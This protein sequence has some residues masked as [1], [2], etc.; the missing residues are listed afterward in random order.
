MHRLKNVR[1]GTLI[2]ADAGLKLTPGEEV[3]LDKLSRQ[4]ERAISNGYLARVEAD[5][6]TRPTARRT[7]AQK[8]D[9]GTDEKQSV[10]DKSASS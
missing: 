7:G 4:T 8:A 9:A 6:E 3:A 1:P 5:A 10:E 2:I